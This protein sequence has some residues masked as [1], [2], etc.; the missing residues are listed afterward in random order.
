MISLNIT[1]LIQ[2]AIILTVMILLNQILFKPM[3]RILEE[4]KARTE[5]RRKAA[6][7]LDG[8]A[9]AVWADY[10]KRIQ[11]ARVEAD[12]TRTE[13]VRQGED[14]RRKITDAA[15]DEAEKTTSTVRAR[16]RAEAAEARKTLEAEARRLA[17]SAAQRILGR[18]L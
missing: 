15:A 4:R 13:F 11:E 16:I 9:E 18:S 8:K 7:E 1:L 3:L 14:E 17:D 5:G 6:V 10:Q 2:L 12:R